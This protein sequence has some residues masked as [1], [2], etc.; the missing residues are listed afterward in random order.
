MCPP[1][2]QKSNISFFYSPGTL[3][4]GFESREVS[5]NLNGVGVWMDVQ[6]P[7]GTK[8]CCDPEIRA[9]RD[10]RLAREHSIVEGRV[11]SGMGWMAFVWGVKELDRDKKNGE[12]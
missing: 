7:G 4:Q 9:K 5:K 1:S 10:A 6:W 3:F 12:M 8:I 2:P 11:G